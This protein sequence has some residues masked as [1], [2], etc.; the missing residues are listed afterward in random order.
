MHSLRSL[1]ITKVGSSEYDRF[2]LG[3]SDVFRKNKFSDDISALKANSDID[4]EPTKLAFL[5]AAIYKIEKRKTKQKKKKKEERIERNQKRILDVE[6]NY[7]R[8]VSL[9]TVM[10]DV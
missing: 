2:L 5:T 3:F 4:C 6:I 8:K 10:Y 7:F 9:K 1:K